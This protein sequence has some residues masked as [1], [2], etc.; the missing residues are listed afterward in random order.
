MVVD[1]GPVTS[2]EILA[3]LRDVQDP[4]APVSIVDLGLVSSCGN[5]PDGAIEVEL[6]PTR[7]GCPAREFIRFLVEKR[8]KVAFGDRPVR[9]RWVDAATWSTERITE[10][11]RQQLRE[12]GVA[13]PERDERGSPLVRCPYCGSARAHQES[14]YGASVCRSIW[15][16]ESC[17][18][19]FEVMRWLGSE[20]NAPDQAW[21]SG[22]G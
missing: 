22:H 21:R 19:P 17:R 5:A 2:E 14:A 16:C 1:K 7:A 11:G 6:V 10:E 15:Y 4:E 8:L 9:C 18:S 20:T 3:A 13:V 12:H